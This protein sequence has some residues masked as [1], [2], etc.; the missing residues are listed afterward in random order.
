[1]LQARAVCRPDLTA[2]S[3]KNGNG[4]FE[5]V[6]FMTLYTDVLNFACALREEGIRRGDNVGLMSDNRREWLVADF[7]VLALGAADVPRGCDCAGSE[8]RFILSFTGCA[9]SFF[10]NARQLRKVLE[11]PEDVPRLKTAVLFEKPDEST[12]ADAGACGIAVRYFW[13]MMENGRKA[14]KEEKLEIE[15][16]IEKGMTDDTATILFTSGTTGT[17]KG[18]ML[19]HGNYLAQLEV[20]DRVLD[21]KPGYIWLT[22]LP[23][24]HSFERVMQYIIL[25]L[26]NGL[27]YS[28]PVASVMLPDLAAVRPQWMTGVPRLWESLAQGIFRAMKKEGGVKLAL[29]NFFVKTGKIWTWSRDHVYGR[30]CRFTK[31]WRFPDVIAGIVPFVFLYPLYRLGDVLV[32]GK[33]RMKLGGRFVAGISGGGAL[34]SDT[35]AFYR[36]VGINLLEGYGITEAAPILSFRNCWKPRPGCV[37]EVFPSAEIR[38]V[39]EKDGAPVSGEP[40]PPGH[41]G[42]IMAHGRQI[43]KG[44][45]KNSELTAQAVDKDGWLN[46]GDIGMLTWDNEIKITGRAKDT[47]V[48]LGGENIE[49]LGIENAMNG[50]PYIETT[51]LLG[52]DRKYLAALI[53]PSKDAV[54]AYARE[55]GLT[56]IQYEDIL[57]SAEVNN[58]IRSEID[59]RVNMHNGYRPCERVFRFSLL[60]ESFTVG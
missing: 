31:R 28:K 30:V 49:P 52:Q 3:V 1:M 34:Q 8:S 18:V 9:V 15:A 29:F 38:I 57:E 33:I 20:V 42:L 27:A 54:L 5:N 14:G 55:N 48:L 45:Y 21:V 46:T 25:H 40:L 26:Y 59:S 58:L 23:V 19:T 2:Q 43:M 41:K 17:P 36:A 53:V 37:G 22:V 44:Y 56:D 39:A 50:S 16:E 12:T 7:A 6:S 11:K 24:W 4:E 47:I 13:D 51:V 60:P 35:D 32:F 10:E